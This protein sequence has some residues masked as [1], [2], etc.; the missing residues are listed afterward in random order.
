MLACP[1]PDG[2]GE[3]RHVLIPS[4]S[5]AFVTSNARQPWPGEAYRRLRADALVGMTRAEKARLRFTGRI[6]RA[7][8]SEAVEALRRAKAEHDALEAVCNPFVDFGGVRELAA[9]EAKRLLN[10]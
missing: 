5:L 6:E 9:A 3:L 1:D 4:H 10:G 8:R 2:C 7:L